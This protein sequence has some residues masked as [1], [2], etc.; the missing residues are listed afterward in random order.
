MHVIRVMKAVVCDKIIHLVS[1]G[2]FRK[3][4]VRITPLAQI[5]HQKIWTHSLGSTGFRVL[6]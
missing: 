1:L 4:C 3:F 2:W 5:H 6:R